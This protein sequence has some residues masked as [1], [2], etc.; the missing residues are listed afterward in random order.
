VQIR[1]I[2]GKNKQIRRNLPAKANYLNLFLVNPLKIIPN[3]KKNCIMYIPSRNNSFSGL[4]GL[5]IIAGVVLLGYYAITGFMNLIWW[6]FPVI[7][8][9]TLIIDYKV[10]INHFKAI[11]NAF[12]RDMLRGLLY[13]GFTFFAA[14]VV[15]TW[16]LF[17]AIA[18][19][20][21]AT[22]QARMQDRM[23]D[24]FQEGLGGLGNSQQPKKQSP[25]YFTEYEEIE[26]TIRQ[27]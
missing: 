19:K 11:G 15:A 22:F 3:L 16:L 25:E 20:R 4:T 1:V 6:A 26:T 7:V 12:Q 17:K 14:P 13:A 18:K 23:Q 10:V 2:R 27:R 24:R 8:V 9:A 21:L 5:L